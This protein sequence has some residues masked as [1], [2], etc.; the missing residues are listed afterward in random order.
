MTTTTRR[1]ALHLSA[2]TLLA[3]VAAPVLCAAAA[4][5]DAELLALCVKF[6]R[7]AAAFDAVPES[8]DD[9]VSDDVMDARWRITD[10][11]EDMTPTTEAGRKAKAEIA[12]FLLE[13][14]RGPD[15]R[16]ESA[17]L[18]FAYATLLDMAGRAVA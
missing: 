6:H 15:V 14:N 13:E 4:S 10:Q 7:Q 12:V 16:D 5:P 3:G 9:Q 2:S 18:S 8:A 17:D 1:G 11:I